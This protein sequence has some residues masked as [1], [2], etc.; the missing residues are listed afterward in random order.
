MRVR[1]RVQAA[2]QLLRGALVRAHR[3][4]EPLLQRGQRTVGP[5]VRVR[6]RGRLTLG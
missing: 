2:Q 6:V 4:V 1:V 5:L 3:G